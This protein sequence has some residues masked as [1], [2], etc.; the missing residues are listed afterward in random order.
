MPFNQYKD[1]ELS[2]LA[3]QRL[4]GSGFMIEMMQRLRNALL[5][6]QQAANR[7]TLAMYV[8]AGV[9]L[10]VTLYQIFFK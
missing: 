4:R 6:E 1:E 9:Q 7:L 3:E 2:E 8:L 10:G 5:A